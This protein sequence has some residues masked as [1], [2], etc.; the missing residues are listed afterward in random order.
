MPKLNV[1]VWTFVIALSA[2]WQAAAGQVATRDLMVEH[3]IKALEWVGGGTPLNAQE[4][5]QAA[6]VVDMAMRDAPDRWRQQD[7]AMADLLSNLARGSAP[8]KNAL[9]DANRYAYAFPSGSG[10]PREFA[11]EQRIIDAHDPVL[12]Q[13]AAQKRVV[14]EHMMQSLA[15]SSAWIASRFKLPPPASDFETVVRA[16]LRKQ[17]G[18]VEPAI[19]DGLAH[20]ERDAWYLSAYFDHIPEPRRTNFFSGTRDKTFHNISNPTDE[21]WQLAEAAGMMARFAAQQAPA[22]GAGSASISEQSLMQQLTQKALTG[23][24]RSMSPECNVTVGSYSDRAQNNCYP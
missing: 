21:Q 12:A 4:R 23:A 17:L 9:W 1:G 10:W 5:E 16:T 14:T 7:S 20:I 19:G 15:Q 22:Q 6:Q 2:A 18:T 11:I 3:E 24:M 13:D 8:Y